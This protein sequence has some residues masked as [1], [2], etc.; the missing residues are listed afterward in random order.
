M[1]LNS[2]LFKIFTVNIN[3]IMSNYSLLVTIVCPMCTVGYQPSLFL[4]VVELYHSDSAKNMTP[5]M[6]VDINRT[7]K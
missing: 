1:T 6:V 7:I 3:K 5:N 2:T 4:L